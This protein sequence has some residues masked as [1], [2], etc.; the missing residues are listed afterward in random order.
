MVDSPTTARHHAVGKGSRM[1]SP[2]GE[3]EGVD[4]LTD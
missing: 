3:G 1:T 2:G 4:K